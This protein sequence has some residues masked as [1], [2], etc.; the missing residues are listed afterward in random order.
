MFIHVLKLNQWTTWVLDA[1]LINQ[2]I[3][4]DHRQ[5]L[6]FSFNFPRFPL[7]PFYTSIKMLK[8]SETFSWLLRRQWKTSQNI[9]L[10]LGS[11]MVREI[12]EIFSLLLSSVTKRMNKRYPSTESSRF[13]TKSNNR[14]N[15][16]STWTTCMYSSATMKDRNQNRNQLKKVSGARVLQI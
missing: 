11:R 12:S 2:V 10:N 8:N 13:I 16:N 7:Q 1:D 14:R 6:I 5:V 3:E 15:K 9:K 4:P